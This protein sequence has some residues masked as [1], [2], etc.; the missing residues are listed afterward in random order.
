MGN[1]VD[2]NNKKRLAAS[3]VESEALQAIGSDTNAELLASDSTM[4]VSK[5]APTYSGVAYTGGTLTQPSYQHPMVIDLKGVKIA[6]SPQVSLYGHDANVPVG[7]HTPVV[8]ATE[9]RMEDGHFSVPSEKTTMVVEAGKAGFPWQTSVRGPILKMHFLKEGKDIQ[10]NGRNFKG[11]LYVI[12]EFLFRET[13]F[14]GLGADQGSPEAA[15]AASLAKKG[16]P[17]MDDSVSTD[18]VEEVLAEAIQTEETAVEIVANDGETPVAEATPVEEVVTEDAPCCDNPV[19]DGSCCA[20]P[21][22][23]DVVETPVVEDVVE[24]PV[25]EP[26]PVE[27]EAP[28]EPVVEEPVVVAAAAEL[29]V[30]ELAASEETVEE[31]APVAADISAAYVEQQTAIAMVEKTFGDN[32]IYAELKASAITNMWDE[33]TC[34]KEKLT[35]DTENKAPEGFVSRDIEA[36]FNMNDVL[37]CS[38]AI[39]AGV[40]A[41]SPSLDSY[42]DDVRD[43]AASAEYRGC[44]WHTAIHH[45]AKASG[46]SLRIGAQGTE[47]LAAAGDMD[48]MSNI[49][50]A[51]GEVQAAQ[52]WSTMDLG[53][54]TTDVMNKVL[55]SRFNLYPSVLNDIAIVNSAK[56]CR[57]THRYQLD[58]GGFMS[59]LAKTGEI[60]H[61]TFSQTEFSNQVDTV[62]AMISVPRKSIINDDLGVFTQ[63]GEEFGRGAAKTLERDLITKLYAAMSWDATNQINGVFDP[64]NLD[65]ALD[66]Y[67]D[68]VDT[69]GTPI[70]VTPSVLFVQSGSMYRQALSLVN[71]GDITQPEPSTNKAVSSNTSAGIVN[72]VISS[73][74]LKNSSVANASAT[75]WFLL[76][77]P[78]ELAVLEVLFL[79][80]KQAPSVERSETTFNTLGGQ[81]RAYFDYGIAPVNNIGIVRSTGTV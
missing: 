55:H 52:G 12:S 77:S 64:T 39:E 26:A 54:L 33:T 8:T 14:T 67:T 40:A 69:D 7:H 28:V 59:K 68:L 75:G 71:G 62:A 76:P 18:K 48:M 50:R 1:K 24:T 79:N 13:S 21:V 57:P 49:R 35:M 46:K 43:L 74:W 4:T 58:G 27:A 53:V 36:D 17:A 81:W 31:V 45:A 80:G 25:E 16:A 3:G 11:P 32:P 47:L 34:T 9:I 5:T 42:S 38:M 73:P 61:K 15:I 2:R 56:D 65:I 78:A 37:A 44:G 30:A 6:K 19:E 41:N 22:V 20:E 10:L 72:N 29:A 63:I 23:E 70:D 60:E 66:L 51:S